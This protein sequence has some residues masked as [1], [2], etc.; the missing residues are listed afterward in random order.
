MTQFREMKL[1]DIKGMTIKNTEIINMK[2]VI[3]FLE[4]DEKFTISSEDAFSGIDYKIEKPEIDEKIR[5]SDLRK[6]LDDF[7]NDSI[8]ILY[9]SK[10]EQV[11]KSELYDYVEEVI[12]TP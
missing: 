12:C 11:L 7:S 4:I 10:G 6:N 8:F 2:V 5:I 3:S 9:N 1:E